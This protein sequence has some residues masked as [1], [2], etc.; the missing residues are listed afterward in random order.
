MVF[1]CASQMR[2]TKVLLLIA[3]AIDLLVLLLVLL[4]V[5]L[6]LVVLGLCCAVLCCAV[7][8]CAAGHGI[9]QRLNVARPHHVARGCFCHLQPGG[10]QWQQLYQRVRVHRPLCAELLSSAAAVA[11]PCTPACY[12]SYIICGWPLSLSLSLSKS[13]SFFLSF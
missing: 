4:V 5:V 12:H 2:R 7:L 10:Y 6:L 1:V 13:L 3:I 8:C 11:R 9:L